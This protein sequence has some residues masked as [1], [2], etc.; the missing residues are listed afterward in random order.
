MKLRM[1]DCFLHSVIKRMKM[2]T[3]S[4]SMLVWQISL[5]KTK[6][7]NE[8]RVNEWNNRHNSK[9]KR[10]LE[11]WTVK[12]RVRVA[13]VVRKHCECSERKMV[14]DC[15]LKSLRPYLARIFCYRILGLCS[16]ILLWVSTGWGQPHRSH[17]VSNRTLACRN[18]HKI[19]CVF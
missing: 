15:L 7:M 3:V 16:G 18:S 2:C 9:K 17:S 11:D 5:N 19:E 6:W 14:F 13:F 8:M 4:L 12:S 1:N 10:T